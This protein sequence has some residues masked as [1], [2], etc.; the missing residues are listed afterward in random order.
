MKT[1]IDQIAI[2][3]T[4]AVLVWAHSACLAPQLPRDRHGIESHLCP[5]CL[6]VTAIM[7]L[8]VMKAA[9]R[10]RDGR[11]VIREQDRA[12][13]INRRIRGRVEIAVQDRRGERDGSLVFSTPLHYSCGA[14]SRW[15]CRRRR[16]DTL[17]E[18]AR[19]RTLVR[20]APG[21]YFYECTGRRSL[22][23]RLP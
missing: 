5:P 18:V 11:R 15:T 21:Q 4:G 7:Q 13:Q 20:D 16:F 22:R 6:L 23:Y 10:Q 8:A 9:E 2:A 17:F 12:G 19:P 1:D 14:S 3:V